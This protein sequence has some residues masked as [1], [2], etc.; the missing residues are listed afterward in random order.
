M[1]PIVARLKRFIW[2]K[3]NKNKPS[4]YT[5]TVHLGGLFI[6]SYNGHLL[7]RQNKP[8]ENSVRYN[9]IG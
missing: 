6:D 3:F 1:L 8:K 4:Q 9:H 5:L 7:L 2:P